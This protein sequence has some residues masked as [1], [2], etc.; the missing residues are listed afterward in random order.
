MNFTRRSYLKQSSLSGLGLFYNW[1]ILGMKKIQATP[2]KQDLWDSFQISVL[3][4]VLTLTLRKQTKQSVSVGLV[5]NLLVG[6]DNFSS[7]DLNYL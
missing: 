7:L 4:P 5:P 3:H 2:A 6:C 1:Y